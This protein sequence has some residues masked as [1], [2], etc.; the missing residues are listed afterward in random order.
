MRRRI[1]ARLR[2]EVES[3]AGALC[4]YCKSPAKFSTA[5]FSIDHI[6]PRAAE[7][8]DV[9]ENL[10]YSCLGCNDYKHA[11]TEATDPLTG[12]VVRLYNPRTDDWAAHFDCSIDLEI[13]IG[14]TPI[15]RATVERLRLNREG[16]V[17]LRRALRMADFHPAARRATEQ[18]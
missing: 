6:L 15:G 13:V 18:E 16:V 10:A 8:T 14:L 9:F 11:A 17:N 5:G 7:G 3:R 12:D 4:E 1:D 2:K